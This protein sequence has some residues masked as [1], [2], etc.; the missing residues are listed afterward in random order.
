MKTLATL[1]HIFMMA[2]PIGIILTFGFQA[3]RA[4]INRSDAII[5][6]LLW[7]I[8]YVAY[9][10]ML[11]PSIQDYKEHKKKYRNER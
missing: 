1:Y 8:V 2:A 4:M 3:I 6:V 11:I 5:V 9:K 7:A 10:L